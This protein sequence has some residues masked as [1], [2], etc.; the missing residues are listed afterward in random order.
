MIDEILGGVFVS[1]G[2]ILGQIFCE[3]IFELVLKGPGYIIVK[4]LSR[5]DVNPD[6][7]AVVMS[8][9]IFW[10]VVGGAAYATYNYLHPS[11]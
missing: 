3:I 4:A 1:L 8:G 11:W 7:Y 2:R 10:L 6:G 5:S 9:V